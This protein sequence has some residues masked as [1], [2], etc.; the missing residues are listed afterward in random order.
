[1]MPAWSAFARDGD[2][3]RVGTVPWPAWD[4]EGKATLMIGSD[5]GVALAP[6]AREL[7][8]LAAH[9]PDA[10]LRLRIESG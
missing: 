6:Q 2:P 9:L 4:P 7:E 3:A 10:S 8:T 1:M 5:V